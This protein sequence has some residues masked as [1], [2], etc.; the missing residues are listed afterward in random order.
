MSHT[1]P[2]PLVVRSIVLSWHRTS[3][4][5]LVSLRSS[6]MMSTP[7]PITD[8]IAGMEFSGQLRQSP[9][10]ET[11]TT[12]RDEGLWSSARTNRALS[13]VSAAGCEQ[14]YRPAVAQRMSR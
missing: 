3:T 11:T 14:A 13:V 9:R 10:C 2:R 6:S 1:R 4:L 12:Y 5:S 8:S 7:M